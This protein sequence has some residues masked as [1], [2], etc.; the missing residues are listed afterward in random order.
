MF[1]VFGGGF[2]FD[3]GDFEHRVKDQ[4]LEKE[5]NVPLKEQ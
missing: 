3:S 4:N 2:E 1:F 5:L